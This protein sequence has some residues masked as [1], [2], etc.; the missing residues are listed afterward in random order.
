MKWTH[1][2]L[3]LL[4]AAFVLLLTLVFVILPDK[5][6]S[7]A[8]KRNLQTLPELNASTLADG[9]YMNALEDYTADQFPLRDDWMRVKT[10]ISRA[11]GT[12][13]SQGV[14]IMKD[15]SL[16]ERFDTPDAENMQ[17]TID[18]M[19]AFAERY[20][21]LRMNFLLVPTAIGI[22]PENLPT[23]APTDSEDDYIDTFYNALS[24]NMNCIDVR[25]TFQNKKNDLQLY[26]RT[27]HHWTTDAAYEAY[28]IV[29]KTMQFEHET[30]FT[31]GIICNDFRGSLVSESGFSVKV[32]DAIT[33][34]IPNMTDR[35]DEALYTVTYAEDSR[36]TA[37][38][39]ETEYLMSDD[40]YQVFFGSNHP[41]I[42]IDTA[43][44]T[45]RKLLVV[46]DSYANCFVPFLT[47]EF[48]KITI[49]DPRYYYED[50]DALVISGGYTDVLF[51]Y[52]AATLSEDTSLKT[53]LQNVQ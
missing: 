49:V 32:P 43:V 28:K 4:F 7:S 34:Y 2:I 38:C 12:R 27:D 18:A 5:T 23:G 31:S 48:A 45:D 19:A 13:E 25:E 16:A 51:L 44:V 36:K 3:G 52:N 47:P 20:P 22:Y 46:K 29:S 15:G 17:E 21:N 37:S 39:F 33:A 11:L 1:R 14:Y 53:V 8:E 9:S 40:Q 42:Q 50:I 6:Y 26:Y 35:P 10:A 24:K 41:L 30:T